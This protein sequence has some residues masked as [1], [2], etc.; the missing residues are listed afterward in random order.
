MARALLVVLVLT[1]FWNSVSTK[2]THRRTATNA[3]PFWVK[4]QREQ[5]AWRTELRRRGH[6]FE[7]GRESCNLERSKS[8]CSR[9]GRWVG[10][11][12][13]GRQPLHARACGLGAPGVNAT[14]DATDWSESVNELSL[15]LRIQ[16]KR[17]VV[18]DR[19]RDWGGSALRVTGPGRLRRQTVGEAK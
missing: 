3:M 2:A 9:E 1:C 12:T 18:S 8:S 16:Q 19:W 15:D 11:S 14:G 17:G 5:A 13:V 10:P 4:K 7:I 6:T